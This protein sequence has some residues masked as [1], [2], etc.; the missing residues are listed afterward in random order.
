MSE[1]AKT[2]KKQYQAKYPDMSE[3]QIESLVREF[4]M[5]QS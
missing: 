2:I 1:L 5:Y 4:F 3:T